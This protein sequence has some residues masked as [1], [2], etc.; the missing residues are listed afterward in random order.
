MNCSRDWY[1]R[2]TACRRGDRIRCSIGTRT[3]HMLTTVLG[4]EPPCQLLP[5]LRPLLRGQPTHRRGPCG[6][7]VS[8][9]AM[10]HPNQGLNVLS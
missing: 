2:L 8:A 7:P 6:P 9:D 1:G 10:G 4:T 5:R 3:L